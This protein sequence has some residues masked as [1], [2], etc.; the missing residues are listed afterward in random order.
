MRIS[1]VITA[2]LLAGCAQPSSV[3]QTV[4]RAPVVCEP[5]AVLNE[6]RQARRYP[7]NCPD[8]PELINRYNLGLRIA[9]LEE[10]VREINYLIASRGS[11]GPIGSVAYGRRSFRGFGSSGYLIGRR[12]DVKDELRF[13]KREAG[14]DS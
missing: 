9:E 4:A 6:G 3:G 7:A 8:T 12:S 10:E 2:A 11:R 13:L 1:L 5:A 14:L